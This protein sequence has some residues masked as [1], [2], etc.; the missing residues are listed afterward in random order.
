MLARWQQQVR[1]CSMKALAGQHH[2][3][4]LQARALAGWLQRTRYK[5]WRDLQRRAAVRFR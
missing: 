5:L 4:T 2:S 3:C 1:W